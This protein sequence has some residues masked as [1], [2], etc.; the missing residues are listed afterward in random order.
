M[1]KE[2]ECQ[3]YDTKTYHSDLMEGTTQH[4]IAKVQDAVT[5]LWPPRLS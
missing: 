1:G 3:F 5:T 2:D 4:S